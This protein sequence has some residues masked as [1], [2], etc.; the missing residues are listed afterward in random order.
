VG[1]EGKI[2]HGALEEGFDRINRIYRI[3]GIG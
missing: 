2:N 1:M 3:L